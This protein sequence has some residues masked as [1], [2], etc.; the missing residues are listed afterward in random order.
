MKVRDVR[1]AINKPCLLPD[2]CPGRPHAHQKKKHM[3]SPSHA[4]KRFLVIFHPISTETQPKKS[5]ELSP[6]S[7][8]RSHVHQTS[9]IQVASECASMLPS[10]HVSRRQRP[11]SPSH[12]PARHDAPGGFCAGNWREKGRMVEHRQLSWTLNLWYFRFLCFQFVRTPSSAIVSQ[13]LFL[14]LM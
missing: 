1:P 12:S 7:P 3:G 10:S 9:C 8:C 4:P 14:L 11:A 2:G 6:S 13:K 5:L